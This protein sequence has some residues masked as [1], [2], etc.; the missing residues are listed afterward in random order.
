MKQKQVIESG[1][2]R[3]CLTETWFMTFIFCWK[4][5]M[6]I[7]Y[8]YSKDGTMGRWKWESRIIAMRVTHR[9]FCCKQSTLNQTVISGLLKLLWN[10][11]LKHILYLDAEESKGRS[12]WNLGA[13]WNVYKYAGSPISINHHSPL[14]ELHLLRKD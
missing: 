11:L 12:F 10:T 1:F 13:Q 9:L 2:S 3:N 4:T 7:F 5:C 6:A 14:K 8:L